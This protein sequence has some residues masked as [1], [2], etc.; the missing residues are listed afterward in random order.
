MKNAVYYNAKDGSDLPVSTCIIS[1]SVSTSNFIAGIP[2]TVIKKFHPYKTEDFQAHHLK[3][4]HVNNFIRFIFLLFNMLQISIITVL[5]FKNHLVLL[6]KVSNNHSSIKLL[7]S[8]K[9]T[10]LNWPEIL[11]KIFK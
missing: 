10:V 6:N 7:K 1:I 9:M 8:F 5:R 11:G 3:Y 2:C 4:L